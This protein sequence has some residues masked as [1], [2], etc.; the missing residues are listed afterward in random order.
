L[1]DILVRGGRLVDPV[2]GIDAVSDIAISGGRITA[3]AP[4]LRPVNTWVVDASDKLVIPGLVDLHVHLSGENNGRSGH[5]MLADAG[6]TTAIDLLGPVG[7]VVETATKHGA[8]LTVGCVEGLD[9]ERYFD[10]QRRPSRRDVHRAILEA[11]R[12][13]ALGVKVHV[14]HGYDAEHS[15][16]I[17]EEANRLGVWVAIHCGSTDSSSDLT[18]LRE[19][20]NYVGQHHAQIAHINSYCRGERENP[21]AE[22]AE[23]I[24]LLRRRPQVLSES[25]LSE[26]NGNSARLVDGQPSQRVRAWLAN[27]GF[28][29]NTSGLVE[30]M[31][32]GWAQIPVATDAGVELLTG[33][34]AVAAW[35][36]A[37]SQTG[38]CLPLNPASS[39]VA[40]ALSR[41]ARGSFDVGAFASDGG[42]IPRNVTLNV[43]LALVEAGLISVADLVRKGSVQGARALGL[44]GKG[45]L[46][47]G[48]EADLVVVDPT[49]RRVI[50]TVASGQ[51]VAG[52][53][54]NGAPQGATL[55]TAHLAARNRMPA[56][57]T[58][59]TLD[60]SDSGFY[61]G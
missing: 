57:S 41:D 58:Q 13:G 34:D 19:A 17:V 50:L 8:G 6:V 20:L 37:D 40:L 52:V 26:L 43:G 27:A 29:P 55:L 48:A 18:G 24:R 31:S 36:A 23:A 60:L 54:A 39:R 28:S 7:D 46:G 38:L 30:A 21:I 53:R 12:H 15:A 56:M 61:A 3:V 2:N 44:P 22:A 25:Y 51:I 42:G 14:E 49:S 11:C 59:R 33:A 4:S 9:P 35:N 10:G 16:I 47:E 32:S 45:H 1:A 5:R